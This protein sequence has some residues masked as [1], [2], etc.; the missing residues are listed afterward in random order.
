MKRFEHSENASAAAEKLRTNRSTDGTDMYERWWDLEEPAFLNNFDQRFFVDSEVNTE[1]A[2]RIQFLVEQRRLCGLVTGPSGV[3]K[4][5]QI[6]SALRSLNA[7]MPEIAIVD[8]AGL[9]YEEVLR[10]LAGALHS[11]TGSNLSEFTV[12]RSIID[13]IVGGQMA[14]NQTVIVFDHIDQCGPGALQVIERLLNLQP[15]AKGGHTLIVSCCQVTTP[16]LPQS[17]DLRIRLSGMERDQTRRYIE[18]RLSIAGRP[19]EKP[20]IFSNQ[21]VDAIHACSGGFPRHINRV[22][23]LSMLMSV[24]QQQQTVS[25]EKV[26]EAAADLFS[27]DAAA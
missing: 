19:A 21:A 22:C 4:S 12:W 27:G 11:P 3:G 16:M 5:F 9:P 13:H 1:S 15:T 20:A 18:Q 26:H 14:D 23:E 17:A 25:A 8:V 10:E 2:A 24:A 6:R 7:P